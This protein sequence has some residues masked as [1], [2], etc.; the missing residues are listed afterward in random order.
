MISLRGKR[1][2]SVSVERRKF[3]VPEAIAKNARYPYGNRIVQPENSKG[4]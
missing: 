3:G 1:G 4:Q 2:A